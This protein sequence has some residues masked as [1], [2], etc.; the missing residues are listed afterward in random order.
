MLSARRGDGVPYVLAPPAGSLPR[1]LTVDRA[2]ARAAELA[3]QFWSLGADGAALVEDVF[4]TPGARGHGIATEMLRF[5]VGRAR[6]Q[7]AGWVQ[8]GAEVDDTPKHLYARF[9]FRPIAV[10]RSYS[11]A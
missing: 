4:V 7:G 10:T 11:R 6:R 3:E 2:A 1:M 5:A 9:G 8:I